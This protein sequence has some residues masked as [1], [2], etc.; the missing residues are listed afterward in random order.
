[1]VRR[2]WRRRKPQALLSG[3]CRAAQHARFGSDLGRL[4]RGERPT[5]SFVTSAVF[6]DIVT[7]LAG[8]HA[9]NA[10]AP[11]RVTADVDFLVPHERFAEAQARL[12]DAGWRKS[13]D[14]VFPNAKLGLY[15]GACREPVL[16]TDADILASPQ[17][18]AH[19]AFTA[20]PSHDQNGARVLPLPFLVLMQL[21]SACGVDQGNLSRMLGRLDDAAIE[22][23]LEIVERYYDDH[24]AAEDVRQYALIGRWE[25]QMSH[26]TRKSDDAERY[27]AEDH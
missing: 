6:G 21:D 3:A 20:T 14:L 10:Y 22:H 13:C 4:M 9:A 19:A 25:Y 15:G 27:G 18:W 23:I 1:M 12:R 7:M 2:R 8:A 26:V 5:I 24:Q 17:A 11:P 16:H